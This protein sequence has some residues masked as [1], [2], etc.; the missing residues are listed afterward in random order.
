MRGTFS[1]AVCSDFKIFLYSVLTIKLTQNSLSVCCSIPAFWHTHTGFTAAK[2]ETYIPFIVLYMYLDTEDAR[3][4][5]SNLTSKTLSVC[6]DGGVGI[7]Q[8]SRVPC[9][10]GG[11]G[12]EELGPMGGGGR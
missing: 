6:R 8:R 4:R 2:Y 11:G 9:G 12:P 3:I 10:G 1:K 5:V 7:E